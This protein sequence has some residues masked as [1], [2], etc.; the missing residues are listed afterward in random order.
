MLVVIKRLNNQRH[1][2]EDAKF[3][4]EIW[5]DYKN[6]EYFMKTQILNRK[7]VYWALYLSRFNF[8]LKHVL[9]TKIGKMDELSR[10]LDD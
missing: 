4:F 1:L 2:L 5:I 7:Q 6:L 3:R 8:T 9:I 10:R